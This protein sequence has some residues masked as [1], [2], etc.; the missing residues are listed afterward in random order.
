[1]TEQAIFLAFAQTH[2]NGTIVKAAF[3]LQTQT[4]VK[5]KKGWGLLPHLIPLTSESSSVLKGKCCLIRSSLS[6]QEQ[7]EVSSPHAQ[8]SSS[9]TTAFWAEL[10]A[11]S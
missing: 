5:G 3:S 11:G 9:V 6:A 7:Q 8:S 10:N 2:S 1:M 4:I